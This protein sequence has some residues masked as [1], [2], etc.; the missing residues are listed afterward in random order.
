MNISQCSCEQGKDGSPHSHQAAIFLH[1]GLPSV[2]FIPV[3]DPKGKQT[4]AYIAHGE[5]AVQDLSFYCTLAQ[6]LSSNTQDT[7]PDNK[8]FEPDFSASC[9]KH[10]R[11][12]VTSDAEDGNESDEAHSSKE[13]KSLDTLSAEVDFITDDI[14]KDL[15]NELFANSVK[16]FV[17]TY[18]KLSTKP[19][20]A[21]LMSSLHRFGWCFGG[22]F[23]SMKSGMLRRGRRIPIQ[24]K[25]AGRRKGGKR[26]KSAIS[27]GRRPKAAF[28]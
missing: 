7:Q 16:K 4:L 11:V 13:N 12:G 18:R 24:A 20:N 9:W 14:K 15:Q 21:S 6:P 22:T 10:I 8:N 19:S 1:F 27:A 23:T 17:S 28:T 2:N 26:G 3:M 25:S 5:V